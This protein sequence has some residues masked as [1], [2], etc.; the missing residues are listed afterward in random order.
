PR[1]KPGAPYRN[2]GGQHRR[3]RVARQVEHLSGTLRHERPQIVTESVR[4]FR[5]GRTDISMRREVI[6]HADLLRSLPGEDK[7]EHHVHRR[8]TDPQVKPPPTPSSMTC[9]PVRMR[10]SRA[11]TSSASGIEAADVFAC[12][13]TVV[14]RRSIGNLSFLTVASMMRIFA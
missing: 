8:S 1:R 2:V 10:P 11:A 6:Q 5:K 13:S 12:T 4:C 7:R 9:C 3:L 14:M